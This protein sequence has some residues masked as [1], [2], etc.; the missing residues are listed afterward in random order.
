MDHAA[1]LLH[2]AGHRDI[3]RAEHD[4][5]EAREGLRPDD[6]IGE[7]G[8]VLDREKN[9]AVG[10]A[11]PLAHGDE[12]GNRDPLAGRDFAQRRVAHDAAGGKISAQEARRMRP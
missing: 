5:A 12:A 3:A 1:F 8:L 11:R 9:H 6:D 10:R 7:R 4:R 2:A